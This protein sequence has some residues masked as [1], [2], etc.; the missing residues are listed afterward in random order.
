MQLVKIESLYRNYFTQVLV[1]AGEPFQDSL[2]M[3]IETLRVLLASSVSSK[4]LTWAFVKG[5][6]VAF[7]FA[8]GF[9]LPFFV[10]HNLFNTPHA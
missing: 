7:L 5:G 4:S 3:Q 2:S 9:S 8:N 1:A 10:C 6:L